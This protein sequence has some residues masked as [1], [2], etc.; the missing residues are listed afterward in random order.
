MRCLGFI[1]GMIF[2]FFCAC[3]NETPRWVFDEEGGSLKH[4]NDDVTVH[5]SDVADNDAADIDVTEQPDDYEP[6]ENETRRSD[7]RCS[8]E[9]GGY[10]EEVYHS[11]KWEITEK[12]LHPQFNISLINDMNDSENDLIPLF[13]KKIA[14]ELIIYTLKND[15]ENYIPEIFTTDGTAAGTKKF[16]RLKQSYRF[17]PFSYNL[18][19][20]MSYING[21]IFYMG[22]DDAGE[23]FNLYSVDPLTCEETNLT[24]SVDKLE[25]LEFTEDLDNYFKH[26][27]FPDT[28]V[29]FSENDGKAFFIDVAA[30]TIINI[31]E[32]NLFEGSLQVD[33]KLFYQTENDDGSLALNVFNS[34]DRSFTTILDS[35][36]EYTI[37]SMNFVEGNSNVLISLSTSEYGYAI[38]KTDGTT[39]GTTL[40]EEDD[41]KIG[42]FSSGKEINGIFYYTDNINGI[43]FK[44]SNDY[45]S[46][47]RIVETD[48]LI[49]N[50]EIISVDG[51]I[52]LIL[53]SNYQSYQVNSYSLADGK[54]ISEIN[55]SKYRPLLMV[56]GEK[57]SFISS[58]EDTSVAI[59]EEKNESFRK[60]G[61]LIKPSKKISSHNS[62]SH[63]F[64][65]VFK[66]NG[67]Y[68]IQITQTLSDVHHGIRDN[69][70]T[71][72]YL[73]ITGGTITGTQMLDSK[74][75][76]GDGFQN[77]VVDFLGDMLV[78]V[79]E[80][81]KGDRNIIRYISSEDQE[82]LL[83]LGTE[84]TKDS[85]IE[86]S[87]AKDHG[88]YY[89]VVSHNNK[90][91][92]KGTIY[93]YDGSELLK[94]IYSE[95]IGYEE[96]LDEPSF[97]D[98]MRVVGDGVFAVRGKDLIYIDGVNARTL[99]YNNKG[100]ENYWINLNF[101][102]DSELYFSIEFN[103]V[104]ENVSTTREYLFRAYDQEI[105]EVK[106]INDMV[107]DGTNRYRRFAVLSKVNGRLILSSESTDL[108]ADSALCFLDENGNISWGPKKLFKVNGFFHQFDNDQRLIFYGT[109]SGEGMELWFTDGTLGG[110]GLLKDITPGKEGSVCTEMFEKDN[111]LFFIADNKLWK[112]SGRPFSTEFYAFLDEP[113]E[114]T[115]RFLTLNDENYFI[116]VKHIH[117]TAVEFNS[118]LILTRINENGST[119][120]LWSSTVAD[121]K[122]EVKSFKFFDGLM[123]FD[124]EDMTDTSKYREILV[125]DGRKDG[126]KVVSQIADDFPKNN[127]ELT[128]LKNYIF[129]SGKTP[130]HGNEPRK[131]DIVYK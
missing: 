18:A 93:F 43:V 32:L 61:I 103:A 128:F 1:S 64:N 105:E 23:S 11:G 104:I 45:S 127:S 119:Y 82:I 112:T 38:W 111:I 115:G 89:S 120:E 69:L 2:L 19:D 122:I 30:G 29:V 130:D 125:A 73:F 129:F 58:E 77:Y 59:Y 126:V 41:E 97:I 20:N 48:K 46:V 85:N 3:E 14:D 116:G 40:I 17:S 84:G 83:R 65:T 12:C 114:Y 37:K 26:Y 131:M 76:K 27:S 66:N 123:F 6:V 106:K 9:F 75:D 86:V 50:E 110:T 47:E 28:L 34:E 124:L 16:C 109:T 57:I 22:M 96:C 33:R 90:S 60:S 72:N 25:P 107:F 54:L 62:V 56:N 63:R 49:E 98:D 67:T 4:E 5:D 52:Y 31:V 21:K 74:W 79:N 78:M 113:V 36:S 108:M 42:D 8:D 15:G 70:L 68:L 7:V 100:L 24:A 53:S 88:V 92:D 94:T 39:T 55:T 81:E 10:Y 95:I 117:T 121:A 51:K 99:S 71:D 44:V 80:D 91:N 35:Q 118:E 101:S 13:T 87:T 102:N